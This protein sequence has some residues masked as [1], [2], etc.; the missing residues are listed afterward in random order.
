MAVQPLLRDARE[1]RVLKHAF[2]LRCFAAPECRSVSATTLTRIL[3]LLGRKLKPVSGSH[4]QW[5][6]FQAFPLQHLPREKAWRADNDIDGP[7]HQGQ[8]NRLLRRNCKYGA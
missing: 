4:R 7:A 2:R 8:R 5:K 6:G 1:V 3:I